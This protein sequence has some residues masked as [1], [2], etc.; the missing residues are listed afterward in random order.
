MFTPSVHTGTAPRSGARWRTSQFCDAPP[1]GTSAA[2]EGP[3][4][5]VDMEEPSLRSRLGPGFGDEQGTP[6]APSV[7]MAIRTESFRGRTSMSGVHSWTTASR[8][9]SFLGAPVSYVSILPGLTSGRLDGAARD[10]PAG[11]PPTPQ[12]VSSISTRKRTAEEFLRTAGGDET[13]EMPWERRR[14]DTSL[15]SWSAH[16]PSECSTATEVS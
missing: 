4:G 13:I 10:Q 3:Q 5:L 11:P 6:L 1:P 16:S 14:R 9:K 8:R 2:Q 12:K 7:Q 15:A